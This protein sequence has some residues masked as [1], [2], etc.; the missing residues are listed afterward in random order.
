M[1]EAQGMAE[2]V[3]GDAFDIELARFAGGRPT[4]G[5]AESHGEPAHAIRRVILDAGGG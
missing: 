4:Y 1:I 3:R 5:V 2:F